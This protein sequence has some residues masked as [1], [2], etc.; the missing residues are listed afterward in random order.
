MRE[1]RR[2]LQLEDL[3]QRRAAYVTQRDQAREQADAGTRE[4]RLQI[5]LQLKTERAVHQANNEAKA[6]AKRE[7]RRKLGAKKLQFIEEQKLQYRKEWLSNLLRE[8]DVTDSAGSMGPTKG[9]RTTWINEDNVAARLMS[10]SLRRSSPVDDWEGISRSLLEEEEK[11]A[12]AEYSAGMLH[13]APSAS[14]GASGG[15]A[16]ETQQETPEGAAARELTKHDG[17]VLLKTQINRAG[18]DGSGA[19]TQLDF[20]PKHGEPGGVAILREKV[21]LL[22]GEEAPRAEL[23]LSAASDPQ[24][25][26]LKRHADAKGPTPVSVASSEEQEFLNELRKRMNQLEGGPSAGGEPAVKEGK[27]PEKD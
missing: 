2:E 23:G 27:V 13:S 22:P 4:E 6:A 5:K 11:A 26:T 12:S 7:H 10:L 14:S 1:L 21:A 19:F 3:L 20:V 16:G 15:R 18:N 17:S 8:N 25:R 9:A 24:R